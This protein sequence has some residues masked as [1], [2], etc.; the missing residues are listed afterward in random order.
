MRVSRRSRWYVLALTHAAM[1]GAIV[2]SV[3]ICLTVMLMRNPP[4]LQSD[5]VGVRR[6][7]RPEKLTDLEKKSTEIFGR[8]SVMQ[9]TLRD[10]RSIGVTYV[11][12]MGVPR[13]PFVTHITLAAGAATRRHRPRRSR[14]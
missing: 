8:D 13:A 6:D 7:G 14:R 3:T 2:A 5:E 12:A 4:A 9:L 10:F 1:S 11:T